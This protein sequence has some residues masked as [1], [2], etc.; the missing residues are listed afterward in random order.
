MRTCFFPTNPSCNP[1]L[2]VR[3]GS[4]AEPA[5][6]APVYARSPEKYNTSSPSQFSRLPSHLQQHGEWSRREP[7]YAHAPATAPPPMLH[8]MLP[9]CRYYTNLTGWP[10]LTA[11]PV[12]D[13]LWPRLATFFPPRMDHLFS[14]DHL[15]ST[16]YPHL[17]PPDIFGWWP[18]WSPY[19]R[20]LLASSAK[21]AHHTH[22]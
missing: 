13:H 12:R 15:F 3:C 19:M 18:P 10:S 1:M 11:V 14:V 9:D 22:M 21:W 2:I 6:R 5:L 7:F 8:S 17:G 16:L 20:V 4:V